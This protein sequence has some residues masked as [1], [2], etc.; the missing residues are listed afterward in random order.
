[1]TD[2]K[3]DGRYMML[4]HEVRSK[5]TIEQLKLRREKHFLSFS[6]TI[7]RCRRYMCSRFVRIVCVWFSIVCRQLV[8]ASTCC[9]H[10]NLYVDVI[11]PF[12]SFAYDSQLLG[13]AF[14]ATQND[15]FYCGWLDFWAQRYGRHHC[16]RRHN[17]RRCRHRRNTV[18]VAYHIHIAWCCKSS[19]DE[20][21][22]QTKEFRIK[23]NQI[24][25]SK[26]WVE[27]NTTKSF[28]TNGKKDETNK[29]FW[30]GVVNY[31]WDDNPFSQ[32]LLSH[33]L[34]SSLTPHS[35]CVPIQLL[36]IIKAAL[37]KNILAHNP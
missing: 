3:C 22:W 37:T 24:K 7:H 19:C 31:H 17:R 6:A 25:E 18:N 26:E 27:K 12:A 13:N 5:R 1:M 16:H 35:S 20:M 34:S 4:A 30:E 36:N 21:K 29:V 15:T 11:W 9:L 32:P 33:A 28:P 14:T 8:N 10:M 23:K 2:C